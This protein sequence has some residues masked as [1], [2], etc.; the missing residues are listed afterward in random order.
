MKYVFRKDPPTRKNARWKKQAASTMLKGLIDYVGLARA[1][2]L[3]NEYRRTINKSPVLP[4]TIARYGNG[5]YAGSGPFPYWVCGFVA[6]MG[7][8]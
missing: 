4:Q 1:T 2:A 6:S 5:Y 7:E 8:K 3:A